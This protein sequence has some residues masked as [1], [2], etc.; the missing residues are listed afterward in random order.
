[1]QGRAFL[2]VAREVILG[3]TEAH[4]RAVVI[5]AYYALFLECRDA[6]TRWGIAFR[7]HQNVHS[8]VRLL[9]LYAADP[10]LKRLGRDLD[11]WCGHRNH[12]SYNLSALRKFT[13]VRLA[14]DAIAEATSALALLDAIEG[15]PVRRA[16][17]VAA[18]PP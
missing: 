3:P 17:A 2:E 16:A 18:F 5:H 15:D 13:T 7:P 11:R 1:M 12:A 9:F 8:A 14:Q 10:D 6:L 4:W